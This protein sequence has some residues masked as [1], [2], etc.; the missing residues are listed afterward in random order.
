[1]TIGL[2]Q[3]NPVYKNIID[4]TLTIGSIGD[5]G[6][7]FGYN[8]FDLNTDIIPGLPKVAVAVPNIKYTE[9]QVLQSVFPE[10]TPITI[11]IPNNMDLPLGAAPGV[12][13]EDNQYKIITNSV[14]TINEHEYG[15]TRINV[16][17]PNRDR[18]TGAEF[19]KM[20]KFYEDTPDKN[21]ALIIDCVSIKFI[22]M[23]KNGG[24]DEIRGLKCFLLKAP[25]LE[26]DPGGKKNINDKIFN[27]NGEDGV[28]LKPAVP[29]N[30]NENG[31]YTYNYDST[32]SNSL[33]GG[34]FTEYNFTL[35]ELVLQKKFIFENLS[36]TLT[37]TNKNK[38]LP[39]IIV[40]DSGNKN[41]INA[42]STLIEKFKD[43][44]R[45]NISKTENEFNI[46][47]SFQQKRTGDWLQALLTA[48]VANGERQFVE[49]KE[50]EKTPINF[51]HND[52]YLVTH[53]R[54]LLAFALLLG[55]NVI[56]THKKPEQNGDSVHSAIIY[57]INNPAELLEQ[58]RK[59]VSDFDATVSANTFLTRLDDLNEKLNVVKNAIDT[60]ALKETYN[61]ALQTAIVAI[62]K[63]IVLKT[64]NKST[65]VI[66]NS[67]FILN[68]LALE[69][70][71]V[72]KL[73]GDIAGFNSN[74]NPE[75]LS[76]LSESAK[77]EASI[78]TV[79]AEIISVETINTINAT[80]KEL[81]NKINQALIELTGITAE[82]IKKKVESINKKSKI[83][84]LID[85]WDWQS[86]TKY[87]ID[88]EGNY[89]K[90]LEISRKK[91]EKNIFLANLNHLPPE[92]AN[93]INSVYYGLYNKIISDE[94]TFEPALS[95]KLNA[96]FKDRMASFCIEVLININ[97]R[98]ED[99]VPDKT[100]TIKEY[101]LNFSKE[102]AVGV[103]AEKVKELEDAGVVVAPNDN[104]MKYENE[105]NIA[106]LIEENILINGGKIPVQEPVQEE[107]SYVGGFFSES[108]GYNYDYNDYQTNINLL[109]STVLF[110]TDV[111]HPLLPIYLILGSFYK[112]LDL[113]L[114]NREPE[115]NE[116]GWWDYDLYYKFYLIMSYICDL[117]K[118][119]TYNYSD[120]T[121]K[122][123]GC[124]LR[125]LLFSSN[126]YN[127][128]IS[129]EEEENN[130]ART[131]A[132]KGLLGLDDKNYNY[133][134]MLCSLFSNG[135][136]GS[137]MN[138]SENYN[139]GTDYI[140][141]IKDFFESEAILNIMK[142][143][144]KNLDD[145]NKKKELIYK[146]KE[147]Y[148]RI[149][150]QIINVERGLPEFFAPASSKTQ[151]KNQMSNKFR[152]KS[153]QQ[154]RYEKSLIDRKTKRTQRKNEKSK[155][156]TLK[157]FRIVPR[158]SA[159]SRQTKRR[160][161]PEEGL[162][163]EGTLA[164]KARKFATGIDSDDSDIGA[165]SDTDYEEATISRK[166]PASY[167]LTKPTRV[168]GQSIRG[169]T[170]K[171]I[172]RKYKKTHRQRKNKKH[173]TNKIKRVR[174][175][176][177]TRK[178]RH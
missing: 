117:Y 140:V 23:I 110:S 26:N 2:S 45:K 95:D 68:L 156:Q 43:L 170:R 91:N 105:F 166:R 102:L 51:M 7:D 132:E 21:I 137:I 175:N 104:R 164:K 153:K 83:S 25:E 141:K 178:N 161:S 148:G 159:L 11:T 87:S 130:T 146:T 88:A 103:V 80:Y 56:F 58:K 22:E 113:I 125:E 147:L 121:K 31:E 47:A 174:K 115:Y 149:G 70:P 133:F 71:N 40:P 4:K 65:Q 67:A 6:H 69:T 73:I 97:A 64:I 66:F 157:S 111:F 29:Y 177:Y 76:A 38:T 118:R 158:P 86:S 30:F 81:I 63:P 13:L 46:N 119:K 17:R 74:Y 84:Q 96:I 89:T 112:Q 176:K 33:Y 53:D 1:M 79:A 27:D 142:N 155:K 92:I 126:Q 163:P 143:D 152:A 78:A 41:E 145:E 34:F 108:E 109:M 44:W 100:E 24:R 32:N 75:Y 18:I 168:R 154:T 28:Y 3:Q 54:I 134:T 136:C 135:V 39:P 20:G 57:R 35:S 59:L 14:K 172:N 101:I 49:H 99:I 160:L 77:G 169:G 114:N 60:T 36:S 150:L 123:I 94:I 173:S 93:E 48:L 129:Q 138:D 128:Y 127:G 116:N 5:A 37:I 98:T 9:V 171:Y 8:S 85:K 124:G 106:T 50:T 122:I 16:K 52:V 165:E 19:F 144:S 151:T 42:L 120:E 12:A 131:L 55:V 82:T 139:K 61:T 162:S 167:Y 90:E 62:N 72:D 107:F 15:I 10:D